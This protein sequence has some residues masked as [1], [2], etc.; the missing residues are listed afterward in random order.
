MINTFVFVTLFLLLFIME[1]VNM[2]K[3]D[4]LEE[5]ILQLTRENEQLSGK[6][7]EIYNKNNMR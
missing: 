2:R 4:T 3:L 7:L 5:K 6:M 1:C